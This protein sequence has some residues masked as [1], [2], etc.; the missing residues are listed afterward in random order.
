MLL[1]LWLLTVV[2][3]ALRLTLGL[4][5]TK[6]FLENAE[7]CALD[8]ET[9]RIWK[10]CCAL[11]GVSG[12]QLLVSKDLSGPVTLRF[13][14]DAMV[15][16]SGFSAEIAAEEMRAAML[17]ECAH[18]RRRDFRN[19]LLYQVIALP[20]LFH[21]AV[22][23]IKQQLAAT[24]EM[25]CDAAAIAATGDSF[26]Y[27]SALLQLAMWMRSR[28]QAGAIHAVGI[29]DANVL[30]ERIMRIRSSSSVLPRAVRLSLIGLSGC[31]V[32]VG[33]TTAMASSVAVAPQT[34]TLGSRA[35]ADPKVYVAGKNATAPQLVFAVDPEYS[36]AA[37]AAK[38]NG[39]C[40]IA[41]VVDTLGVP[42][43]VHVTD[44]L[45][46]DLDANAI[47]AVKQYRFKPGLHEGRPVPVQLT[48]A[49][50]F[51]IF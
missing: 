45:R 1:S 19:N 43:H 17:H 2:Y 51:Q 34:T 11:M 37:R 30:E 33:V 29:F 24:R 15:L 27:G 6:R 22:W 14:M 39:K 9:G 48:V 13:R 46:P 28:T 16:R 4:V 10:E 50:N 8:N 31:V 7:L 26:A 25:A 5:R 18:M 38:V 41:A 3:G 23:L 47:A 21:P 42:Q 49:V 32:A 20:V 40:V 36:A 35:S 12:A 44:G